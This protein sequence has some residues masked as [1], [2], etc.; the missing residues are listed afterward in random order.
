MRNIN[1]LNVREIPIKQMLLIKL[2]KV[3]VKLTSSQHIK[4][5][6]KYFASGTWQKVLLAF[7][8]ACEQLW[9]PILL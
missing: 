9:L 1:R 3:A 8:S 6:P 2:I 4:L 7:Y 5:F